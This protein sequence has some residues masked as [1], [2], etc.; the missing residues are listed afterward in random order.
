MTAFTWHTDPGHEW[1]A[2]TLTQLKQVGMKPADFSQY[3]YA[4]RDYV[5]L[6]GDCD[7]GPFIKAWRDRYGTIQ[8]STT[9]TNTQSF[10]R[11]LKRI[12]Q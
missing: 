5:F 1:L 4:Y 7:A 6:E 10:V 8:F 11:N 3:S 12:G 9:H 2:V